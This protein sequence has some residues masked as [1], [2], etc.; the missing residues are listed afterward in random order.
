MPDLH[1]FFDALHCLYPPDERDRIQGILAVGADRCEPCSRLLTLF[2][3]SRLTVIDL[4]EEAIA[5]AG[6]RLTNHANRL[7][8]LAGN[9]GDLPELAPGPYDLV[10]IRHPDI[11]K[12]P[13][14]WASA[15]AACVAQLKVGGLLLVTT[16]SLPEASLINRVLEASPVVLRTGS[17]YTIVPVALKGNDRYILLYKHLEKELS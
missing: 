12:H 17:P 5:S 8:I 13:A 7:R 1:R 11:D 2:P 16:Y 15:L 9:A 14:G 6:A 4:D 3:N 10:I